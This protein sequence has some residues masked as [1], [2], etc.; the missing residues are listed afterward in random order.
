MYYFR[1]FCCKFLICKDFPLLGIRDFKITVQLSLSTLAT[2]Y[3]RS[4]SVFGCS[5]EFEEL[6]LRLMIDNNLRQPYNAADSRALY[7]TLLRLINTK[8]SIDMGIQVN[9]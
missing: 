6:V 8:L 4:K 3:I 1:C 5:H 7:D 2:P 9:S